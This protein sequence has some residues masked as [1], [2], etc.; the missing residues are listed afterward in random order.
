MSLS[1]SNSSADTANE[2]AGET[3]HILADLHCHSRCS[4]GELT[5]AALV[6]R[7]HQQGVTMLA[8][9]DHDTTD[10][11]RAARAKG[12]E[13]GVKLINGI[14]FSSVWNGMGIHIVGLGFDLVHPVMVA[15]VAEQEHRR[16]SRAELIGARLDKLGMPGMLQAAT[17]KADGGQIG[18][19]H[20]AHAMVE[21]GHVKNIGAAFKRFLGAGKPGDVKA[22]WPDMTQVVE[23]I[24]AAGGTAV[25]AHP[26]KYKLT[27]TKFNLLLKAFV[28]AGG[29]GLEVVGSGMERSFSQKMAQCCLD[30]NLYASQGSDFH[31]P[32]PWAEL[33]RLD[34][35]PK[36]VVPVWSQWV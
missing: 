27:R 4:D 30:Y 24:R 3:P 20:F 23:W 1:S 6:E 26:D 36:D 19:P 11:I 28:E 8:L 15:A 16:Q 7:A 18:R 12:D 31:G 14:E 22:E 21:S 10:G 17:A 25:I 34:P 29:N 5:P 32:K 9:T 33:G 35:M 13:L 2:T